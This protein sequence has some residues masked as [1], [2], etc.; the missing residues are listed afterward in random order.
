IQVHAFGAVEKLA[1]HL[2]I[3][4]RQNEKNG[5]CVVC[6]GFENLKFI[7]NKILPQTG[8][9][10]SGR[11]FHQICERPLKIL[12][13]SQNRESGCAAAGKL[14]G[15]QSYR[16]RPRST[17]LDGDA[18]LSSAITAGPSWAMAC[19]RRRNPRG[20]CSAALFSRSRIFA[21]ERARAARSR[22]AARISSSLVMG[23]GSLKY[24]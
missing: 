19:S 23:S 24:M 2:V 9:I 16:K 8:K 1:E 10:S 7:H 22:A 4:R 17:P 20:W 6:A 11:C 15:Q 14:A 3:E 21:P 18:F 12:L 13:V 5:I